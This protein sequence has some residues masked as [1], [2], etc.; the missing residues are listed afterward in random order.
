MPGQPF[1]ANVIGIPHIPSII[2]INVRL[3]PARFY[4]VSALLSV[5]LRNLQILDIRDDEQ[6]EQLNNKVYQ[7]LLLALPTGGTAWARDDL[8]EVQGDGAAFGYGNITQ[9]TVAFN[10]TR[11]VSVVPMPATVST[12]NFATAPVGVRTDAGPVAPAPAPAPVANFV[13]HIIGLPA[14]PTIM[15]VNTRSG[16]GTNNPIL[17]KLVVGARD[18]RIVDVQADAQRASQNGRIYQWFALSLADGRTGWVRDDLIEIQGDGSEWGYGHIAQPMQA[19]NL[20]RDTRVSSPAPAANPPSFIAPTSTTDEAFARCMF[21]GGVN[22]RPGPGTNHNPVVERFQLGD[23]ARILD[24]KP[25]EDGTPLRWILLEYR[26]KKAWVREDFVRLRGGFERFGLGF[27]DLYPSSAPQSTWSRD[28][29]PQGAWMTRHDGWDHS[30]SVG[31]PILAGPNGGF[32]VQSAF[33]MACGTQAVS[34][35]QKGIQVGSQQA[36]TL[37]W[38]FGYGHYVMVRYL[39]NQLPASTQ[40][41]LRQIG[42]TGQH[43]FVMYAHLHNILAQ[44]GQQLSA[45]QQIGTMGNS[46]N[47]TGAHL[48]LEIRSGADADEPR[49]ANLRSGL[50]NPGVLFLR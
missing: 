6:G 31:A 26:D 10:L 25:S 1:L 46:G 50:L 34:V 5:G 35:Q 44:T 22:M 9:P 24:A 7:W 29:D 3:G 37:P 21:P 49:W 13:A 40:Q 16:P 32:V 12:R 28:Y 33:C 4:D 43:I 30:G 39:H 17:A 11:K 38:N 36:L 19:A 47:S 18:L 23:E 2:Q 41:H 8:V 20:V 15:T 48:H 45:N 14:F 27:S 42:R